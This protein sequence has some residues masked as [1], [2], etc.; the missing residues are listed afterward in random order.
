MPLY[1][2]LADIEIRLIGKVKFTDDL[3]DENK[4][5][6]ALALRLIDEAEGEIEYRLSQRYAIPFV[7]ILDG[8]FASLP[9]RPT[10][11]QLRTL[12]ELEAVRRILQTDFGK[13]SAASGDAYAKDV[14]EDIEKRI[15]RLIGCLDEKTR[16]R[17][18]FP[19]LPD[20]KLAAHNSMGDDG[21]A[22][23][24]LVTG[25]GRGSYPAGE[26]NNPAETFY[27]GEVENFGVE[28]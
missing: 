18:R 16:G 2:A 7:S 26:I 6:R 9:A 12:C 1:I 21:F 25:S 27:N 5:P 11:E 20:L 13:G 8:T 28:I 23:Q 10:S 19:P 17:Y 4:M 3:T 22:G 24:I 15:E 14:A